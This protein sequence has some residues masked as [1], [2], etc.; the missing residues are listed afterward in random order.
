MNTTKCLPLYAV[1]LLWSLAPQ[2]ASAMIEWRVSVKVFLNSTNGWP[3]GDTA[4]NLFR[5]RSREVIEQ[6]FRNYNALFDRM[7]W[8][9][10]LNLTEI[11]E[12]SGLSEWYDAD[13]RNNW[14][15]SWL[16]FEAKRHPDQYVYRNSALNIYLNNN[17]AGYSGGHLPQLGD[18]IMV[19]ARSGPTTMLHE[20]GHG[21]GLCH[22]HGCLCDDDCEGVSDLID[23]TLGDSDKWTDRN[24]IATNAFNRPYLWLNPDQRRQVDDTWENLMSYHVSNTNL[25]NRFTHDQW[26][27]MVDV[28]NKE[29]W[30]ISSGRTYFVDHGN[31]CGLPP[32]LADV[33]LS[34][35]PLPNPNF[36]WGARH[37][38]GQAF[39][40]GGI[41]F[42][43]CL[44]GPYKKL[45]DGLKRAADG[46]R[47]QIK[48]GNYNEKLRITKRVTL[49]TDR[50][51]VA[52]GR[53]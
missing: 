51:L 53:P 22:T 4:T 33:E 9:F 26:E 20:I 10:K 3:I 35:I 39:T 45:E 43:F 47:L 25:V 49:A 19:G 32:L 37:P 12:L 7:G 40:W 28:S 23:D 34:Q 1:L 13:A 14:D 21:M 16:E 52:I 24:Q 38:V 30:N 27:K 17:S 5:W 29:K 31:N 46:D 6:Q 36:D 48:A 42:N 44:G 15:R 11:V 18:V 8:G 2:A 50:G 41:D